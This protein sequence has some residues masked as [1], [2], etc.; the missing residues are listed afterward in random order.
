MLRMEMGKMARPR[1]HPA[2]KAVL[3]IDWQVSLTALQRKNLSV[4][5]AEVKAGIKDVVE[6]E[7]ADL[8]I[9]AE[10]GD[11]LVLEVVVDVS[12]P[13]VLIDV[14]V[15]LAVVV[16]LYVGVA[17]LQKRGDIAQIDE[18]VVHRLGAEVLTDPG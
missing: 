1:L 5:A 13:E 8:E 3:R 17:L 14:E 7:A 10:T 4:G 18:D 6:V 12:V 16:D 9:A 15:R 11:V 2:R